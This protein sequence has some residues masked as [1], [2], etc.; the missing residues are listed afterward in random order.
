LIE[1]GSYQRN[2]SYKLLTKKGLFELEFA[3]RERLKQ[4]IIAR[5]AFRQAGD[6]PTDRVM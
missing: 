1:P 5:H 3:L 2:N 4:E 6:L